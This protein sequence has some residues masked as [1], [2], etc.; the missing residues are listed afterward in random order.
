[1]GD[2]IWHEHPGK[3]TA[4]PDVYVRER[5]EAAALVGRADLL[6]QQADSLSHIN[7]SRCSSPARQHPA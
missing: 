4:A 7:I 3:P 5:R 2:F 1:M 6:G